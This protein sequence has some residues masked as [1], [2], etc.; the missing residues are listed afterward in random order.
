MLGHSVVVA[1]NFAVEAAAAGI[2]VVAGTE[3]IGL[4]LVSNLAGLG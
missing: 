2:V 4:H 1:W 3:H